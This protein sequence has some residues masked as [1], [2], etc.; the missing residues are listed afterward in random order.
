MCPW[1]PDAFAIFFS[2]LCPYS[3][4]TPNPGTGCF[5]RPKLARARASLA[6]VHIYAK[7]CVYDSWSPSQ[8]KAAGRL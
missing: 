8:R 3:L 5:V 6:G 4:L 2:T 1:F 7:V